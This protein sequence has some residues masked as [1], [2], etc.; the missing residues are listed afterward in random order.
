MSLSFGILG[1]VTSVW[2]NFDWWLFEKF[3][4]KVLE[5]CKL[6]CS[7]CMNN[8]P[9][10]QPDPTTFVLRIPEVGIK[11]PQRD[12][13]FCIEEPNQQENCFIASAEVWNS[14]QSLA[15]TNRWESYSKHLRPIAVYLD[16]EKYRQFADGGAT[17]SVAVTKVKTCEPSET[18]G[19]GV[20]PFVPPWSHY[21]A[22]VFFLKEA[23]AFRRWESQNRLSL[24]IW[25]TGYLVVWEL[26]RCRQVCWFDAWSW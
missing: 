19:T 5:A 7:S 22:I 1:Q 2:L 10:S 11:T 15:S 12:I 20:N 24:K 14:A 16:M 4:L 8:L 23:V 17:N 25:W 13:P 3:L 26:K 18:E 21:K 9:R 6:V